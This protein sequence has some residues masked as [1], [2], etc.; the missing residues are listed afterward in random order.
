MLTEHDA[1]TILAYIANE[2]LHDCI[3]WRCDTKY[4]PITIF[5]SCNDLFWW[6]TADLEKLT[7]ENL[8]ILKQAIEDAKKVDPVLGVLRGCNL[9]CCR[10][11]GMRPQQPAYPKD[12]KWRAL[13]DACGPYR[14]PEEEG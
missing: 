5:V 4:A 14:Y 6:G 8:P 3:W 10:V 7:I 9:F 11:R 1:I 13:F 12:E 2:D